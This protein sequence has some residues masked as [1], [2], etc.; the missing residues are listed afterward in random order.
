MKIPSCLDSEVWV[1][2]MDTGGIGAGRIVYAVA[3]AC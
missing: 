1:S 2:T 3:G